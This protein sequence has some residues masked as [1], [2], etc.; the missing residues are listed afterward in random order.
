MAASSSGGGELP[1]P[2]QPGESLLYHCKKVSLLQRPGVGKVTDCKK[3][4]LYVTTRRAVWTRKNDP[5]VAVSFVELGGLKE[6]LKHKAKAQMVLVDESGARMLLSFGKAD[7]SAA[8]ARRNA[9]YLPI[10]DIYNAARNADAAVSQAAAQKAVQ[11]RLEKRDEEIRQ[12]NL[13]VAKEKM[14][15]RERERERERG[16]AG[17]GAGAEGGVGKGTGTGMGSAIDVDAMDVDDDLGSGGRSAANPVFA[18]KSAAASGLSAEQL[19][20]QEAALS[21]DPEL[22]KEYELLVVKGVV[23][24]ADFFRVREERLRAREWG[25]QGQRVGKSNRMLSYL[26]RHQQQS[27]TTNSLRFTITQEIVDE[28]FA[29]WPEVERAYTILVVEGKKMSQGAFW[30]KYLASRHYY[31]SG[32]TRDSVLARNPTRAEIEEDG[33]NGVGG[34]GGAFGAAG[35]GSR[36]RGEGGVRDGGAATDAEGEIS[37]LLDEEQE[38]RAREKAALQVSL[39][40]AH[41]SLERSLSLSRVSLT[42]LPR[43]DLS[44]F[45]LLYLPTYLPTYLSIYV[46]ICPSRASGPGGGH[47][48]V[49]CAER[50]GR[51]PRYHPQRRSQRCKALSTAARGN[52]V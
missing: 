15:E 3:G 2:A 14:E 41:V 7:D 37:S 33:E 42:F 39:A 13:R 32:D 31:G 35:G 38:K 6:A 10:K 48:R 25:P 8:Q 28:I 17:A 30:A 26:D 21:A 19:Q 46:S 18:S 36:R 51:R 1:F 24:H 22:R 16:A 50:Q 23:S 9:A 5:K 12:R 40:H 43:S 4:L 49:R 20:R 52:G 34:G 11:E 29:V 47:C 44:I 45:L 27:T